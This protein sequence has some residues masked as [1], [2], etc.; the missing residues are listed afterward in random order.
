MISC[1]V[2]LDYWILQITSFKKM[3][4]SLLRNQLFH[5]GNVFPEKPEAFL[6]FADL[7]S[8]YMS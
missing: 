3:H 6:V 2:W 7:L 1:R 5:P 8:A 4:L